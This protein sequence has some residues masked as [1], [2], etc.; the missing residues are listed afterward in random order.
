MKKDVTL[1]PLSKDSSWIKR[2]S[3]VRRN[4]I[5]LPSWPRTYLAFDF[6]PERATSFPLSSPK[7]DTYTLTTYK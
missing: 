4:F 1:L 7:T 6:S 2:I 5:R 3:G